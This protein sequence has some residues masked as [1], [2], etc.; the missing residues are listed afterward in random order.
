MRYWCLVACILGASCGLTAQESSEFTSQNMEYAPNY[1]LDPLCGKNYTVT[2]S[3]EFLYWKYYEVSTSYMRTGIG[4]NDTTGAEEPVTEYGTRYLPKY[5]YEPGLR[6]GLTASFGDRNAYDLTA[7]YTR[8]TTH[9]SGKFDRASDLVGSAD[10]GI[11][12]F[13]QGVSGDL[14]MNANIEDH[15]T[16]NWVDLVAGYK[17]DLERHYYIRP[18]AGVAGYFDNG[19]L[20]SEYE[21]IQGSPGSSFGHLSLN[22]YK[23]KTSVWGLGGIAGLDT[24]WSLNKYISLVASFDIRNIV[25]FQSLSAIEPSQDLETGEELNMLNIAYDVMRSGVIWDFKIGPKW[26]LWFACNKYHLSM[27]AAWEVLDSTSGTMA[28]CNI[29]GNDTG[30][31]LSIQGLNLSALFEF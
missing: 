28:F 22:T 11:W 29:R 5:S 23:G 31:R 18:F 26:D 8:F 12:F 13:E 19:T 16:F 27:T 24:F 7:R 14:I 6:V 30:L 2:F 20:N 10:P 21:Y 3:G 4:L 9:G 25:L 15:L 1:A 17:F